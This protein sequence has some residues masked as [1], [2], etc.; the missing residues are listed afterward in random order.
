MITEI[1]GR[2]ID[3]GFNVRQAIVDTHEFSRN[4]RQLSKNIQQYQELIG[5]KVGLSIEEF[6]IFGEYGIAVMLFE[7]TQVTRFSFFEDSTTYSK[8]T[9]AINE[10]VKSDYYFANTFKCYL[11]SFEKGHAI[12]LSKNEAA[13]KLPLLFNKEWQGLYGDLSPTIKTMKQDIESLLSK[14]M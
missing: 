7:K 4:K 6:E 10:G 12:L 11:N 5:T 2:C 13:Q 1:L 8:E 9:T 14:I 3:N